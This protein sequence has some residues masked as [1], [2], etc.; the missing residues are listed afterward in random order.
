[1]DKGGRNCPYLEFREFSLAWADLQLVLPRFPTD[2][3]VSAGVREGRNPVSDRSAR[4][5]PD[6]AVRVASRGRTEA[7]AWKGGLH[8]AK[9]GIGRDAK[10]V[11][12]RPGPVMDACE[13]REPAR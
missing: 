11:L 5:P 13:L 4:G 2:R 1:M 6:I 10:G 8:L 3:R 9:Q 7:L 12:P